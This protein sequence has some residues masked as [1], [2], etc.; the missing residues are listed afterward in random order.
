MGNL[1]DIEYDN[2]TPFIVDATKVRSIM[3][4]DKE[5][6]L[7]GNVAFNLLIEESRK[8]LVVNG[9]DLDPADYPPGV[10]LPT[11]PIGYKR[12][13]TNLKP[14]TYY[15]NDGT[16]IHSYTVPLNNTGTLFFDGEKN[17]PTWSLTTIPQAQPEVEDNLTSVSGTRALSDKQ[18]TILKEFDST[19]NS[20]VV[21]KIHLWAS[22]WYWNDAAV[23]KTKITLAR[24]EDIKQTKVGKYNTALA[25]WVIKDVLPNSRVYDSVT[26]RNYLTTSDAT[27]IEQFNSYVLFSQSVLLL[28]PILSC[29]K[30]LK[31]N[32]KTELKI[33]EVSIVSFT[34]SDTGAQIII[35]LNDA[36]SG[37]L[38][39]QNIVFNVVY[40][41][42][43]DKAKIVLTSDNNICKLTLTVD[44]TNTLNFTAFNAQTLDKS[45]WGR[46][47]ATTVQAPSNSSILIDN[48][49]AVNEIRSWATNWYW[50]D[51][52]DKTKTVFARREDVQQAKVGVYDSDLAT[53]VTKNVEKGA[54]IINNSTRRRFF[55]NNDA[56]LRE[57]FDNYAFFENNTLQL[58]PILSC[59]KDLKIERKQGQQVSEASVVLFSRGDTGAS[60]IINFNDSMSGTLPVQSVVFS[61]NYADHT[62]KSKI[63]LVSDNNFCKLTLVVDFSNALSFSAFNAQTLDKS[64]W[65]RFNAMAVG[66]QSIPNSLLKNVESYSPFFEKNSFSGPLTRDYAQFFKDMLFIYPYD[67]AVYKYF[68]RIIR[69]NYLNDGEANKYQIHLYR[70]PINDVALVNAVPIAT[71]NKAIIDATGVETVELIP[72]STALKSKFYVY[73]DW[74]VLPSSY[75]GVM[76]YENNLLTDLAFKGGTGDIKSKIHISTFAEI[77]QSRLDEVQLGSIT[78]KK[79]FFNAEKLDDYILSTETVSPISDKLRGVKY[80]NLGANIKF[81][82]CD[83]DNVYWFNNKLDNSIGYCSTLSDVLSL[84]ITK[85]RSFDNLP[86][87]CRRLNSGELLVLTEGDWDTQKIAQIWVSSSNRTVWTM[88]MTFDNANNRTQYTNVWGFSQYGSRIL[89]SG[90][91]KR[92]TADEDPNEAKRYFDLN[93]KANYSIYYSFDDGATW[94][95][96]LFNLGNMHPYCISNPQYKPYAHIHATTIDPYWGELIVTHGDLPVEDTPQG[97][98]NRVFRSTNLKEWEQS[99]RD[100]SPIVLQ[101]TSDVFKKFGGVGVLPHS[102]VFGSDDVPNGVY[103][104]ARADKFKVKGDLVFTESKWSYQRANGNPGTAGEYGIWGGYSFYRRNNNQPMYVSN[105]YVT[106]IL[107]QD[108]KRCQVLATWDGYKFFKVWESDYDLVTATNVVLPN[109]YMFVATDDDNNILIQTNDGRFSPFVGEKPQFTG[110]L[111]LIVA[112]GI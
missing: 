51:L 30:D 5:T 39:V 40:S 112:K 32:L 25:Q 98:Q 73:V 56:T 15:W 104:A 28:Y 31:L 48:G 72:Y 22:N 55:L 92:Y 7:V 12:K 89:I 36:M 29:I 2:Q 10:S 20:I 79:S 65:G 43:N 45:L 93:D 68:F 18:G 46:F 96:R 99:I 95:N 82:G 16:N 88:K 6:G 109:T 91:G 52:T 97:Q 3:G 33:R 111:T 101:W 19:N 84:N 4:I 8:D 34:R 17:P 58:Y 49:V 50:N 42:H 100:G 13:I 66:A 106:G 41:D 81:L 110:E 80:V 27:L 62:D 77:S 53:W 9:I 35:N 64:L 94:H 86:V 83:A 60:I 70:Q 21:E 47:N 71:L 11:F 63:V 44:F 87:L 26:K 54:I 75:N 108:H 59:I 74:N 107:P 90:Y 69:K 14:G 23:D 67:P 85:V 24:R 38:P 78:F 57:M 102:L 103:T 76:T 37:T 1:E 105:I 61:V